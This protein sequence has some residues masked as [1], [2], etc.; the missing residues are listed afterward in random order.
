M[1]VATGGAA[2]EA[3]VF[4]GEDDG[5]A[6]Y[7][8][9]DDIVEGLV[10]VVEQFAVAGLPCQDFGG[11][12]GVAQAEDGDRVNDFGEFF[13]D[14]PTRP[15]GRGVG[16]DEFGVGGFELEEL[17]VEGVVFGVADDGGIEDVVAVE[18]VVKLVAE[19][20]EG[21]GHGLWVSLGQ[22]S[23]N[24]LWGAAVATGDDR[25]CLAQ[26]GIFGIWWHKITQIGTSWHKLS[27]SSTC[28]VL[29]LYLYLY[30]IGGSL[31]CVKYFLGN[32][33]CENIP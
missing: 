11:V 33:F 19:G 12:E 18:V 10:F 6:V 32:N 28:C 4:V 14:G 29:F 26:N 25:N 1:A 13:G 15:L 9:F 31:N 2:S 20:L 22:C 27:P 16:G 3:A 8:G 23:N 30:A 24:T 17:L 5:Q 7:F 21:G